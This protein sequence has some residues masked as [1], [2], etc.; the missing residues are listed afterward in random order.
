M[1][2]AAALR[3]QLYR[4]MIRLGIDSLSTSLDYSAPSDNVREAFASGVFIQVAYKISN[5][6]Y[7]TVKDIKA[8]LF[9]RSCCVKSALQW[10]VYHELLH[11]NAL[12]IKT[13]SRIDGTWLVEIA[14]HYYDLSNFAKGKIEVPL[15]RLYKKKEE[16]CLEY[17]SHHYD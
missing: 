12:R 5:G 10:V 8:V 9:H 3:K 17:G 7:L 13:C 2:M 11:S 14:P 6:T 16:K 15:C 4:L 1:Q